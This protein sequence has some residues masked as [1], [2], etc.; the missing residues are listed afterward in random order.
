M[1]EDT[2]CK[3]KEIIDSE[4]KQAMDLIEELLKAQKAPRDLELGLQKVKG[5]LKSIAM[6]NHTGSREFTH[7]GG[8]N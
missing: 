8:G 6:D 5:H 1:A 7:T 4:A 3:A 2:T